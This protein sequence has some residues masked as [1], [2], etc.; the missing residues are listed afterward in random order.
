MLSFCYL[1]S[2]QQRAYEMRISNWSSDVCSADL[3]GLLGIVHAHH[4][5][6]WSAE[7]TARALELAEAGHRYHAIMAMM[8]AEGFPE[9]TIRGFGPAIRKL[10]YG[11]G[12][13]RPWSDRTR[14]G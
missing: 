5:P 3:A 8:V 9:R 10:G 2:T 7:E 1:F 6:C 4:P 14:G 12:R 11:R 13:G